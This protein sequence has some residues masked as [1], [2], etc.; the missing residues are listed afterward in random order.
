MNRFFECLRLGTPT[1][2]YLIVIASITLI[3]LGFY[4]PPLG[5]IHPSILKAIG[6]LGLIGSTFT[7]L[8]HLSE[9]IKAGASVKLSKGD[10][11]VSVSQKEEEVEAL[12]DDENNFEEI[13]E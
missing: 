5:Q 11:S 4:A 9:Y 6:E 3:F 13:D 12:N 1:W 10:L 7:F 8:I 2:L